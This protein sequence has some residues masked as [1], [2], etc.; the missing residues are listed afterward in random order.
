MAIADSVCL[1]LVRDRK[2]LY[3]D[4]INWIITLGRWYY[5][6]CDL[7]GSVTFSKTDWTKYWVVSRVAQRQIQIYGCTVVWKQEK[8]DFLKSPL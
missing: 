8:K 7:F 5:F 4:P 2:S 3:P 1:S 6:K